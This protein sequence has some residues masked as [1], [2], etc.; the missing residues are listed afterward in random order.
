[1]QYKIDFKKGEVKILH[2][3]ENQASAKKSKRQWIRKIK[4]LRKKLQAKIFFHSLIFFQLY[5]RDFCHPAKGGRGQWE[6]HVGM[7]RPDVNT[8]YARWIAAL[9]AVVLRALPAWLARYTSAMM[10]RTSSCSPQWVAH[11]DIKGTVPRDFKLQ[12][13][14][15]SVFPIP[16][17]SH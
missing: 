12:I 9:R 2:F 5:G 8:V 13:Y 7:N 15:E 11:G 10:S 3:R 1:M 17:V 14:H 6:R 16:W 4:S